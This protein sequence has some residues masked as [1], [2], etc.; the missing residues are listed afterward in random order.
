MG[1]SCLICKM[2]RL[3]LVL[4]GCGE[5]SMEPCMAAMVGEAVKIMTVPMTGYLGPLEMALQP[6]DLL[7]VQSRSL[8]RELGHEGPAAR[9]R[10]ETEWFW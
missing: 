9:E 2:G 4:L 8:Q 7:G 10:S 5:N 3:T 1:L 6:L